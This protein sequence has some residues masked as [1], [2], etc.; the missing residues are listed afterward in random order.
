MTSSIDRHGESAWW[1]SPDVLV[2]DRARLDLADASWMVPARTIHARWTRA[3]R[4]LYARLPRLERLRLVDGTGPDLDEL[5]GCL[6]LRGLEV[7][8]VRQ[9]VDVS[10]VAGLVALEML[11]L[12]GLK[13]LHVVPSLARLTRLSWVD[14]GNLPNLD[15]IEGVLA[16]PHLTDLTLVRAVGVASSDAARIAASSVERFEWFAEDVPDRVWVPFREAV[17]LPRS[18]PTTV[19]DWFAARDVLP[20]PA[21][22]AP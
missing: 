1:A 13:E 7:Q 17:G 2:L 3:P 14:L 6:G 20:P 22:P 5:S 9:L 10:A 21:S 15:G 18:V 12:Y 11:S 4:G 8:G 19:D 16:A